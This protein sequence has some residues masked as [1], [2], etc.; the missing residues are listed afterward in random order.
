MPSWLRWQASRSQS[1]G[2]ALDRLIAPVCCS[3]REYRGTSQHRQTSSRDAAYGTLLRE[4][5][6]ALHAR[7]A[8]TLE[9]QFA[10]IRGF[11][12]RTKIKL[13]RSERT[14]LA[15]RLSSRGRRLIAGGTKK[16]PAIAG[17]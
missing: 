10:E 2:S 7:I 1:L 14:A 16:P 4:T 3:G 17:G 13:P 9:C 5:R 12:L 6:R 15:A 11:L 8:E